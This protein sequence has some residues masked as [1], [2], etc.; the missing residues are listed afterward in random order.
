MHIFSYVNFHN[1]RSVRTKKRPFLFSFFW[2][3]SKNGSFFL[4]RILNQ[5]D[6]NDL[7]FPINDHFV[8]T[9][10]H[11]VKRCR[12]SGFRP[13]AMTVGVILME[14]NVVIWSCRVRITVDVIRLSCC[15]TTQQ[16]KSTCVPPVSEV[17]GSVRHGLV[18]IRCGKYHNHT[19]FL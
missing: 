18:A 2:K 15:N 11:H 3:E 8:P 16:K 12:L 6:W 10:P 7:I 19:L 14:V 1:K 5:I 9:Q 4:R 13:T 17:R